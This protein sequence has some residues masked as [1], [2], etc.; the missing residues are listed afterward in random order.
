MPDFINLTCPTCGGK[1]KEVQRFVCSSCGNEYI[2]DRSGSVASRQQSSPQTLGPTIVPPKSE[3]RPSP[4]S[5]TLVHKAF[6]K[7][8]YSV[9]DAGDRIDFIF[10]FQSLLEKD[11]RAFK[12]DVL[13]KDLFDQPILS[14][15]LT[16]EKGL[17]K[18]GTAEWQGGIQFNQFNDS[19]QR[20]L[21][22]D[23][24]DMTVSFICESLIY[25]DGTRELLT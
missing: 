24:S 4:I 10:R 12:G 5:V 22:V 23:P 25:A 9:G 7:A 16:Y 20:L 17:L 19:H 15:T 2:P 8:N 21:T 3:S 1:L 11:V 6:H 18:K 13:F 14:V